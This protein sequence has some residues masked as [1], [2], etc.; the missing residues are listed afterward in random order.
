MIQETSQILSVFMNICIYINTVYTYVLTH[1]KHTYH[2]IHTQ[3]YVLIFV[4]EQIFV[5]MPICVYY[6]HEYVQRE[7]AIQRN[8]HPR[9]KQENRSPFGMEL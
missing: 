2:T 8:S 6:I 1:K 9:K 7:N 5:F 3:I 4:C